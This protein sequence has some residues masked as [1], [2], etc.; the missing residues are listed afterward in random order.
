M[1][2]SVDLVRNDDGTWTARI[3]SQTFRGTYEQ[4]VQWLWWNGENAPLGGNDAP[5]SLS[6]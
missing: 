1:A 6:S 5:P 3:Y 2:R 4:C